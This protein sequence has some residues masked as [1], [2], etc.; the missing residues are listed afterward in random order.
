MNIK[1][2][3]IGGAIALCLVNVKTL[4]ADDV[5]GTATPKHADVESS[6]KGN[7]GANSSGMTS[8][9]VEI[10]ASMAAFDASRKKFLTEQ[11]ALLGSLKGANEVGRAKIRE[12]LESNRAAFLAEVK[13]YRDTLKQDPQE[14]L[15][16]PSFTRIVNKIKEVQLSGI[17]AHGNAQAGSKTHSDTGLDLPAALPLNAARVCG[18]SPLF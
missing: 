8:V 9:P 14:Q 10:K 15:K 6:G 5:N 12:K 16:N 17:E 1:P 2:L 7:D 18:R 3:L 11:K 13:H 4:L